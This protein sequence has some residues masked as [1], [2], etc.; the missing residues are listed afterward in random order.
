MWPASAVVRGCCQTFVAQS[1]THRQLPRRTQLRP[2]FFCEHRLLLS[3]AAYLPPS[4]MVQPPTCP[5]TT[6]TGHPRPH[7]GAPTTP[8]N[9]PHHP[10]SRPDPITVTT[11]TPF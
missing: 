8:T 5:L 7:R 1:G 2:G 11:Q 3:Y 10:R 6:E 4:A 9:F